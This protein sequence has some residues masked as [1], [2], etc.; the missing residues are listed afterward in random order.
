MSAD[1][2][3]VTDFR[4]YFT[5]KDHIMKSMIPAIFD[6]CFD[7]PCICVKFIL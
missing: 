3:I 1:I 2:P 5:M 6:D 7:Y 4:K